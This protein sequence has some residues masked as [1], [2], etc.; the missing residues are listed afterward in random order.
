MPVAGTV[1]GTVA[2]GKLHSTCTEPHRGDEH[3]EHAVVDDEVGQAARLE[4]P[5]HS[6]RAQIPDPVRSGHKLTTHL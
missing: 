1:A 5:L 2:M 3:G 6:L 4:R